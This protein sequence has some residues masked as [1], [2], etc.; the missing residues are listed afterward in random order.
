GVTPVLVPLQLKKVGA[1]DATIGFLNG[2]VVEFMSVACVAIISTWSDRHRGRL[3]RRMP[4]MLYSAPFIALFLIL[5]GFSPQLAAWLKHISPHLFGMISI[6]S[7]TIGVIAVTMIGYRLFDMFPQS[8]Y[9]Y[10]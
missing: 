3:G 2:S 10:L 7:L 6:A 8:V 4:F 5:L 9:Y 1:S